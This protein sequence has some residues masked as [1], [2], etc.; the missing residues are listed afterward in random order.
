MLVPAAL[1]DA[2]KTPTPPPL[3]SA[4]LNVLSL[5]LAAEGK[6]ER[7][8]KRKQQPSGARTD[9]L[10]VILDT[11]T[12]SE[13]DARDGN[14]D[15]RDTQQEVEPSGSELCRVLIGAHEDGQLRPATQ[16]AH[17]QKARV[18]AALSLLLTVSRAAK[19]AALRGN[20]ATTRRIDMGASHLIRWLFI[21]KL[22]RVMDTA[23]IRFVAVWSLRF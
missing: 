10:V 18:T 2:L 21:W 19:G 9:H 15:P 5:L 4:L 23:E 22:D 20:V 11:V 13:Q 17:G 16:A 14:A 6:R 12:C 7:D 3:R 8:H 1:V